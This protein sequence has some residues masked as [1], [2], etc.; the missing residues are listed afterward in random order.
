MSDIKWLEREIKEVEREI[1][2]RALV[3]NQKTVK[4]AALRDRLVSILEKLKE[5]DDDYDDYNDYED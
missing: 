1:E 4:Y 5:L 3:D 2:T